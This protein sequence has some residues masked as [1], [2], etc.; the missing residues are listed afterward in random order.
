MIGLNSADSTFNGGF[1]LDTIGLHDVPIKTGVTWVLAA[2]WAVVVV[3]GTFS[4][5]IKLLANE[6]GGDDVTKGSSDGFGRALNDA[7]VDGRPEP[8]H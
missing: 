3:R 1:S 8:G 7:M 2:M 5:T 6:A 4:F